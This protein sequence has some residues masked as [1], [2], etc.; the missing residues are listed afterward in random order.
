MVKL[1]LM[2]E[3][4]YKEIEVEPVDASPEIALFSRGLIAYTNSRSVGQLLQ[5]ANHH[6]CLSPF[7]IH[8]HSFED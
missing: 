4:R 7:I 1:Q 5:F 3:C 2:E 8:M 6:H